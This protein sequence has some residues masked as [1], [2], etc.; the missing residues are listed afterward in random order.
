MF[1]FHTYLFFFFK[2]RSLIHLKFLL[3]YGVRYGFT[4]FSSCPSINLLKIIFR[5]QWFIMLSLLYTKSQK[6]FG[7][8]LH[9][10]FYFSGLSATLCAIPHC[11]NYRVFRVCFSIC[12]V[13]SLFIGFLSQCFLA[14]LTRLLFQMNFKNMLSSSIDKFDSVIGTE[15][16]L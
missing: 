4:Y 13:W 11:F 16:N 2:C 1:S 6:Y 3:A 12:L 14:I 7:L 5:T 9:L 8:F 10:L 15:L